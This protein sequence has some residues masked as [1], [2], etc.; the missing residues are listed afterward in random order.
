MNLPMD[1]NSKTVFV[2]CSTDDKTIL[3]VARIKRDKP[4]STV[5]AC[6]ERNTNLEEASAVADHVWELPSLVAQKL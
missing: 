2:Y 3:E 1:K 5:V 6:I 4:D